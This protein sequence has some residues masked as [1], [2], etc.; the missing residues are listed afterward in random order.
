MRKANLDDYFDCILF[1]GATLPVKGNKVNLR[2]IE[3]DFEEVTPTGSI[4]L[5]VFDHGPHWM[6]A[7]VD[8][9]GDK[10]VLS[11]GEHNQ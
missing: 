4:Q 11:C 3:I 7:G 5:H 6:F 10:Y 1:N 2:I 9:K 8:S